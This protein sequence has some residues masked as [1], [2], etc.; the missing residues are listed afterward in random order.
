MAT[1]PVTTPATTCKVL[2]PDTRYD[3]KQ[4]LTYD[5]G[6][7]AESVGAQHLCMHLLTIPPGARARAHL[8]QQHETAIYVLS[9]AT[10]MWYGAQLEQHCVVRAGELLFIP[11]GMP[12]SLSNV[13][14]E[15][16]E[17]FEIYAPAGAK[18]DFIAC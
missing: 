9:G 10:E 6:I 18:F 16:F 15:P 14:D 11:A 4:G 13:S 3:G 7:S 12:H 8:H 17:I 1:D 2:R 5:A